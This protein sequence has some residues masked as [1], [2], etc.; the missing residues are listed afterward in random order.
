MDVDHRLAV[1]DEEPLVGRDANSDA[2]RGY[3]ES[4]P[5]YVISPIHIVVDG[6]RVAILGTT[7]GSHLGL[8]DEEESRITVIWIARVTDGRLTEWR[9][10]DDTPS[11]RAE[12]GLPAA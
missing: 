7:T 1:L 4:F 5:E 10:A 3:F 8:P 12:L 9:I 11:H 2:W 6:G